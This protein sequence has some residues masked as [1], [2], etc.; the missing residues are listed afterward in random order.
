M[1]NNKTLSIVILDGYTANPG[2]LS[3]TP[4]ETIGKLTIYD[5]TSPEEVLERCKDADILITNKV[6]LNKE[7]MQKCPKLKYIG[8]SA[9]GYN[10]VDLDAAKE[11]GIV[12]TNV[13]SYSTDAVVQMTFALMLEIMNN[14][15][16]HNAAVK[17]GEWAKSEDFTFWKKP[18]MSIAGKALG[19]IGY[20]SIGKSVAEV[21]KAFG[22]TVLVST[23]TPS[24]I[25]DPDVQAVSLEELYHR[26]DIISLHCPLTEKNIEMINSSSISKMKNGVIIINTARGL[27]VNEADLAAALKGGKVLAAGCDVVSSEPISEDNPLL[28]CDNCFITPHIAWAS[29]ETRH[30]LIDIVIDNIKSF[31]SGNPKNTVN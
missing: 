31:L 1:N 5:R 25:T 18:L 2:D 24:K 6:I 30:E 7:L 16:L 21:A 8:V 3:W 26:A 12:V 11:L 15:A 17:D 19:I 13:P 23:R 29:R 10:V 9:T 27:L 4:L 28:E 22:M 20:G 14:V